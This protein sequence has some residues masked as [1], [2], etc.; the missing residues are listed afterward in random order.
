MPLTD[1]HDFSS[2]L[3]VR[4]AF[5]DGAVAGLAGVLEATGARSA[6]LVVE[7]P[8]A[9]LPAVTAA[10]AACEAAGVRFERYVKGP[11]EP[12]LAQADELGERARTAGAQAVVGIGGGSA[13]D[14]AKAARLVA[15]QGA[16]VARF[17]GGATALEPATTALVLIPTTAG[18]GA[19]VSGASV[20]TDG[21]T[22]RKNVIAGPL[23][24]AHSALVDPSLTL[25]LPPGP[26]AQTG[27]DALAQAIGGTI[28]LN[29]NPLSLAIG[30]EAVRH[31]G[32]AL[33]RAV[34]DGSDVEARREMALGSVL[35][36]LAMNLS[37]CSADH[38][39]GQAV[40][41]LLGLPHG[42]TI[43]LAL[44]ETL[45]VS[46][47]DCADRLERVADALGEPDDGSGDGSRAVRA[48]N[49]L[50]A[51]IGFPTASEAG[52]RA[53]QVDELTRLA[54]EEQAYF[55]EVD[56][57]DWSEADVR[58]AFGRMLALQAR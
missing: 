41:S 3:P 57:H 31:V 33:E 55:L 56:P 15:D 28:V 7:E 18:T 54:R 44:P 30:L 32:R 37:D 2:H 27:V 21:A 45:T 47:P 4:I 34:R 1:V 53:D 46:A 9:E 26:T 50:L 40:G 5:G 29:G 12:K 42:L 24:R 25:G 22:G 52:V 20:L 35:A 8:V 17:T 16:P 10:L 49:R 14:L 38:S 19:E 36:G 11:G 43:G 6:L 13:L 58:N 48:V 39:L 51:A 23:M